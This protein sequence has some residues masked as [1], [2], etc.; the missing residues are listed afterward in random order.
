MS[1]LKVILHPAA[2][3]QISD[4]STRS[5]YDGKN[6]AWRLG[7]LLGTTDGLSVEIL[8]S[9]PALAIPTDSGLSISSST[10]RQLIEQHGAIFK[11]EIVVGWYSVLPLKP[12]Q[13]R[14][15]QDAF[16]AARDTDELLVCAEFIHDR[17]TQLFVQVVKGDKLVPVD[18][19]YK[20]EIA[21]RIAIMQLQSEGKA[22]S[23]VQ[24]TADAYRSLDQ[25][26]KCIEDYLT[27]VAAGKKPF[28]PVLVKQAADVAQWW[29][30]SRGDEE[31]NRELEEAN[32][33]LLIGLMAERLVDFESFA[34][35]IRT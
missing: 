22:E 15:V 14:I 10:L 19:T 8:S 33:A 12:E 7:V 17:E 13:Y 18:Y 27:D 2:M 6:F 35:T 26:L 1:T 34:R 23:Q 11:T 32:L 5:Q 3:F 28:D 30:H 25:H 31:E 20:S 29:N 4:H 21:E 16:T 9:L 24:F